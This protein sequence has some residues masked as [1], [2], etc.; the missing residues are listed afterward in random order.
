MNS[1]TIQ[2]LN[3]LID[4]ATV[5]GPGEIR[6]TKDWV[7]LGQLMTLIFR[8]KEKIIQEGKTNE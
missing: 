7:T 3:E 2:L 1:K 5:K 6:Y 8:A 4:F